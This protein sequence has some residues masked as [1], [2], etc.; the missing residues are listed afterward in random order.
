MNNN[1]TH[2]K[3]QEG[4][5]LME[6][7]ASLVVSSIVFFGMCFIITETSQ[8]HAYEDIKLDS[9]VFANYVLDDIESTIVK[10]S[11]VSISAGIY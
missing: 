6:L 11:N 4:F 10:S 5:T 3:L 8:H 2:N 7:L 1:N 9:K